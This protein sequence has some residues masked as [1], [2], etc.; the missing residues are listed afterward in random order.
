MSVIS[1]WMTRNE[2]ELA[3]SKNEG[4]LPRGRTCTCGINLH[5]IGG[6][7]GTVK[8]AK[9][10]CVDQDKGLDMLLHVGIT[11]GRNSETVSAITRILFNIYIY[12]GKKGRADR[13]FKYRSPSQHRLRLTFISLVQIVYK[14]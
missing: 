14:F 1:E 10:V 8:N 12:I 2:L 13:S 7:I 11:M 6:Q 5:V 9:C 3:P 4:I